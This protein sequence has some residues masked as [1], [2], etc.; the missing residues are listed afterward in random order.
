MPNSSVHEDK[1]GEGSEALETV[2]N[3]QGVLVEMSFL[4]KNESTAPPP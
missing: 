3:L 4:S 2:A 1:K